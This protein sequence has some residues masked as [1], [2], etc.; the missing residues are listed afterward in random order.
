MLFSSLEFADLPKLLLTLGGE[1]QPHPLCMVGMSVIRLISG[2]GSWHSFG[3]SVL[4]HQHG[5]SDD[6]LGYFSHQLCRH[7]V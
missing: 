4:H 3:M 6:G 1:L 2:V 5:G 7:A